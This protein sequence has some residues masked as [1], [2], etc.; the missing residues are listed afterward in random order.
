MSAPATPGANTKAV[1]EAARR[2]CADP[3]V[4]VNHQPFYPQECAVTALAHAGS[5]LADR[6]YLLLCEMTGSESISAFND[7][8]SQAEVLAAFDRAIEAA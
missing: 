1:L 5:D 7:T 8:H 6:A 4:W 3:A 2:K